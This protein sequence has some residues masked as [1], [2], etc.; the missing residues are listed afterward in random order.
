MNSAASARQSPAARRR[1]WPGPSALILI[2]LTAGVLVGLFFGE[3]ASVLQPAADMYI[4][5]MQMTV[6]PYL[7]V[8]LIGGLGRLD[9]MTARRLGFR[10]TLLVVLVILLS[11]IVIGLMPLAF[12]QLRSASFYSDALIEPRQPFALGEIYVPANPFNAMANAVVP[13]VVLFSSAL[14]VALIGVAGKEPLLASLRALESA[15]V[16]VTRFVLRLTPYGVFTIAAAVAG[17]IDPDSLV[18]LEVYFVTFAAASILLAF[19]VLPLT[20]SVLTPFKYREVVSMA[21]DAMITAFVASS[22]FIVLPMLVERVR[23]SLADHAIRSPDAQSSVDVV[24]PISFIVPNAGK[25]LT[26]LFVPYAAWL[27][28][29]PLGAQGYLTLFGAGVPSYFA[30][31]QVALP[32]LLDLVGAPHDLFQLYIP[33]SIVTGKFDSMV[34]AMSLL[35]LALLTASAIGGHLRWAPGR[36]VRA[37]GLAA[38]LTLLTVLCM[39]LLFAGTV[40]TSYHKDEQLRNMHLSREATPVAIRSDL[41]EAGGP[42]GTALQRIRARG[43]LRAGFE[44]GRVP[45]S[46]INAR[47]DLVG[48]DVELATQLARDM[49]ASRVEFVPSDFRQ[50]ALWVAE[51]RLDIGLGLPYV[52]EELG[53]VTYSAPYLDSTLGLVVRDADREVFASVD[54]LR[55]RKQVTIGVTVESAGVA[56]LLRASMPGVKLRFVTLSTPKEMFSGAAPEV[57]AV[58]MLAEAGA[59]WS[60]LYPEF[61]VVVPQPNP[62]VL[63]VGI[64][65]RRGDRDLADFIDD[66]L[67]VM[68]SS[69][70]LRRMR[71]YWVLGRGAE[72]KRP[73]WSV[74]NDVLGWGRRAPPADEASGLR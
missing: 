50:M 33:S 58:A 25:L 32:F 29:S 20:V 73:R 9:R 52:A 72:P 57:D 46:F 22:V 70:A 48:M 30:K 2:G 23:E 60:I 27:A 24:V 47:G 59:A 4:R 53:V 63:P 37:G 39:R 68:R 45:F 18:R 55:K 64:A 6:L 13:A 49:G 43:V 67:V 12:P 17:T 10:A 66:W 5:L 31:A 21:K 1:W 51:G 38:G 14:G 15:V 71:E 3:R 26:L 56:A 42:P 28:G 65:M 41:P 74:L 35:A 34:S 44:P 7:V 62:V 16:L 36:I 61:S 19:V 69:G 54:A 11:V 8:T 40:D